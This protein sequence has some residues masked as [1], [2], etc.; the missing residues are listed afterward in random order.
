MIIVIFL[1]MLLNWSI[2]AM[3]WYILIRKIERISWIRSFEA[4][5]SGVAISSF[6]P[7]RVG[8]YFGR[9]FILERGN[10]IEGVL[11]TFL[12]SMS[13]LLITFVL[14][15]SSIFFLFIGYHT[16]LLFYFSIPDHLY[17]YF[18]W[19]GGVLIFG[20]NILVIFLFLNISVL[21]SLAG[22]LKGKLVE[23]LTSYIHILSVYTVEEL[24]GIIFLS[25]FRFVIFSLQMYLL[26]KIFSVDLPFFQAM[27]IIAVTFFVMTIIPTISI[28]E[29]GIRGSVTLFLI[30]I[31]FGGFESVPQSVKLGIIAAS[32][33]LWIINLAIPALIGAIFVLNLKFFRK[34]KQ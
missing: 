6:T 30:G 2:E 5:L 14:G 13:Q 31:Y 19:G 15:T 8:D 25:L 33:S 34:P 26:L 21:S 20:L 10:R 24:I 9:V 28:T 12:G 29:L 11:I 32:T 4:V 23:K 16:E 18:L 17:V 27:I 1:L 3:K 22:Y 7:N